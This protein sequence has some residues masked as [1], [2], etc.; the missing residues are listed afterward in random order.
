MVVFGVVE[1]DEGALVTGVVAAGAAVGAVALVA[2]AKAASPAMI[3]RKRNGCFIALSVSLLRSAK[4][5]CCTLRVNC[6][7][8]RKGSESNAAAADAV[9]ALGPTPGGCLT[10]FSNMHIQRK[11][12]STL[13]RVCKLIHVLRQKAI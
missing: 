11:H 8:S 6:A 2:R 10:S 7:I 1:V 3:A 13:P 12:W 4:S 9:C 5:L